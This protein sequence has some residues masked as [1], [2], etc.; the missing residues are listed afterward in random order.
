MPGG[1]LQQLI[2]IGDYV[3]QL[4]QVFVNGVDAASGGGL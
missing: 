4:V 3:I 2:G 1:H